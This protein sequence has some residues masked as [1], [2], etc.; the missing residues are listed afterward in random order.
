MIDVGVEGESHS[1]GVFGCC[2]GPY[3]PGTEIHPRL[4]L[5]A[6]QRHRLEGRVAELVADGSL[7][8][9]QADAFLDRLFADPVEI[10]AT[11]ARE[12]RAA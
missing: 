6:P 1:Y 12:S 7:P 10:L 3:G 11:V 8:R 9:D 4:D 2:G 5:A